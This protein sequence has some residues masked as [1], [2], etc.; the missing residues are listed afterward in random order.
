LK[1]TKNKIKF[2]NIKKMKTTIATIAIALT[3]ILGLSKSSFAA[4]TNNEASTVLTDISAVSKIEVHGNVELYLSN[5]SAEQVKVYNSYY[6]ENA[7]V[8]N[9]DGVLRITSYNTEK[10]IVWVTVNDLAELSAFDNAEVKSFGKFSS[11]DLDV[12]L[13]NNASAKL[14]MD[15]I[16]ADVT[17]NDH[18][19]AELAGTINEGNLKF[20]KASDI[21]ITG[22]AASKLAKTERFSGMDNDTAELSMF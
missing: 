22:L 2:K 20:N 11:L 1:T 18:A 10:L 8:Q 6:G 17:L 9:Q 7:M 5:G 4:T 13:F 3:S 19:K 12:K 15:A 16:T 21:N 14:D